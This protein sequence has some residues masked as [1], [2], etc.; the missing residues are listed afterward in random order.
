[1]ANLG[2]HSR[3]K[4]GGGSGFFRYF[5]ALPTPVLVLGADFRITEYNQNLQ[6]L[7]GPPASDFRGESFFDVFEGAIDDSSTLKL[8]GL[9]LKNKQ[10][11]ELPRL[12][13]HTYHFRP[14]CSPV[15]SEDSAVEGI[16]IVFEDITKLSDASEF[17]AHEL[18]LIANSVPIHLNHLDAAERFVFVNK[19][20][21]RWWGLGRQQILGKTIRELAGEEAYKQIGKHI[22]EV[23]SGK[24]VSHEHTFISAD[25]KEGIFKN[26][27]IP[28]LGP[29]GQVQGFVAIGADITELKINETNFRLLA[30]SMP[31]IVW[32][33]DPD[34]FVDYYNK[35]WYDFTGLPEGSTGN[36]LWA[37]VLHP[38]D[39]EKLHET[40]TRVLKTG[41]AYETEFRVKK[42]RTGEYRWLLS[43]AR[44]VRD[45]QGKIKKWYGSNTDIHDHKI[46]MQ[47]LEKE[48]ELRERFVS[49]LSHDLRTP[50]TAAKMSSQIL[51]RRSALGEAELKLLFRI[52]E[53][54]NRADRMIQDLLD[55][56]L[57]KM[58]QK[59]PLKLSDCHLTAVIQGVLDEYSTLHGDRFVFDPGQEL[60]GALDCDGVRRL[61]EN[62]LN[63]GLKYG[64]HNSPITVRLTRVAESARI[65]V[66]N[67]G[68]PIPLEDQPEIFSPYR[69]T[70]AA[71]GGHHRG[72]G[73]GLSLVKGLAEAH[74]GTVELT[75][76]AETGTSF[77]VTLP[78]N[79]G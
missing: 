55:T 54:M 14:L 44:S 65:E 13:L 78:L 40:W 16:L 73:I 67:F 23:L 45:S 33:A 37:Q 62:L 30:D 21:E 5:H 32:T 43:R 56:N 8:L 3:D 27:Y 71:Q 79:P 48:K 10:S 69:R 17:S 36:E 50:L 15:L 9:V 74:G 2:N 7:L 57:L 72:W 77:I 28:E 41:E 76:S 18:N 53:N 24:T 38:D 11:L 6:G 29:E 12:S 42:V 46:L 49:S 31:Q 63:N 51:R 25:G 59:I 47:N 75:S 66:H 1:M 35:R 60:Q 19:E 58:G 22:R 20:V 34:G 52:E 64:S 70:D 26:T 68:N 39:A 61:V 4:E